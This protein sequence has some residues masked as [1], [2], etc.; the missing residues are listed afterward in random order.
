MHEQEIQRIV[1]KH[2]SEMEEMKRQYTLQ[3]DRK[4]AAHEQEIERIRKE[5]RSIRLCEIKV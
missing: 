5:V 3:R 1:G 2:Q 4:N